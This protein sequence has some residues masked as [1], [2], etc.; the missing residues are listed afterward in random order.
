VIHESRGY[1][2]ALLY[3][4]V[5]DPDTR[6]AIRASWGF[7]NW[8]AWMLLEIEHSIFG[9][10]IIYEDLVKLALE[11]TEH[12]EL[13]NR[14]RRRGWLSTLIGGLPAPTAANL[15]LQRVMCPACTAAADTE[16]RYLETLVGLIT[17]DDLHAAYCQSDGLCVPHLFAA[18]RRNGEH[19]EARLLVDLTRER[20]KRLGQE[21]S[22]FVCKHDYRNRVSYTEAEVA[23]YSRAFQMLAGA[24]GVFGND[25]H[26]VARDVDGA[27]EWLFRMS[28]S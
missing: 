19:P 8:H 11:Q 24:R 18:L 23:S 21:L 14:S 13:A 2:D 17:D 12:L 28:A 26:P 3:E 10:A 16:R 27:A 4:Q 1:L 6:R 15:Y 25:V 7:C 5:T 9:S 22:S 20:W